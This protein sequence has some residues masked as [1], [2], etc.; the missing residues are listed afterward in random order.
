VEW[1]CDVEPSPRRQPLPLVKFLRGQAIYSEGDP[2]NRLFIIKTGKVKI[3]RRGA[4][5]REQLLCIMGPSDVFGAVSMFDAGA[6]IADATAIT[7]VSA[8]S[9]NRIALRSLLTDDPQVAEHLLRV[10]ARRLRRSDDTI[11][12]LFATDGPGRVAMKLLELAQQFGTPE[13]AALRVTLDLTQQEIA[14]LIGS[15]RETVNKTLSDFTS[16]GW[17]RPD[18]KSILICEPERLARRAR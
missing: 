18:G 3:G 16:R 13:G 10:L 8:L 4:D 1:I 15:S 14:Q 9:I 2:A 7:D 5:G 17:I 12:G 11:T 6:R